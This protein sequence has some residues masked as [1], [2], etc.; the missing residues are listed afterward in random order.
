[1]GAGWVIVIATVGRS[2]T[3]H[4]AMAYQD[5]RLETYCGAEG[6]TVI[7]GSSHVY[8][9]A[10]ALVTCRR[11]INVARHGWA[12]ERWMEHAPFIKPGV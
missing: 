7:H 8:P 4:F 10:A 1:M 5:E 11:C 6:R 2:A 9:S 12:R 3:V